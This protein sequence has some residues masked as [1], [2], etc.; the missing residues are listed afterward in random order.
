MAMSG[1]EASIDLNKD[2]PERPHPTTK[3]GEDSGSY[4]ERAASFSGVAFSIAFTGFSQRSML[5]QA[6]VGLP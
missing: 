6:Q 3:K 1:C 4:E 5:A 2:V